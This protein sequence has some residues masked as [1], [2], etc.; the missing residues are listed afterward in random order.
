MGGKHS[1]KIDINFDDSNISVTDMMNR[2]KK[3]DSTLDTDIFKSIRININHSTRDIPEIIEKTDEFKVIRNYGSHVYVG[4]IKN[5]KFEII[6]DDNMNKDMDKCKSDVL[7]LTCK[8][9]LV[10]KYKSKKR[11]TRLWNNHHTITIGETYDVKN[12]HIKVVRF[13]FGDRVIESR[14]R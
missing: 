13:K 8:L 12:K 10:H 3:F 1:K 7:N 2:K 5:V 6:D 14:L 11:K 9:S 4:L